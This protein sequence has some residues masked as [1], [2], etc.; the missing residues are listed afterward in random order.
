MQTFWEKLSACCARPEGTA[1]TKRMRPRHDRI[2]QAAQAARANDQR[3]AAM[4]SDLADLS[5]C[6][7]AAPRLEISAGFK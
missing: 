7:P 4:R 1:W 6:E 5:V 2:D 3:F